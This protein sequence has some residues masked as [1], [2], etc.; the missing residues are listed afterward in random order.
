LFSPLFQCLTL[1]LHC[2]AGKPIDFFGLLQGSLLLLE[3][4]VGAIDLFLVA[5]PQKECAEDEGGSDDSAHGKFL[6]DKVE[7][8]PVIL[9]HR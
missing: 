4:V 3:E 9:P 2:F 7:C 1:T 8:I 5:C 6:C